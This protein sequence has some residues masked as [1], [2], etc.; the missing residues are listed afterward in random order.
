MA[1]Q[2]TASVVL[3]PGPTLTA[4]A[5][6]P[7]FALLLA[8]TGAAAFNAFGGARGS[9]PFW[10]FLGLGLGIWALDQGLWIYYQFW[11]H[12]CVPNE[13]IGDPALFLHTAPLMAAL[14][15]RPHLEPSSRRLHQTTFSFLLLVF[16]WV[17][18]YADY[19][20]PHQFLFPNPQMY[21]LRYNALYF[22]E[23]I[24][25]LIVAGTF[26]LCSD[27]PWKLL[28]AHLFGA[29]GLYTLTSEQVNAALNTGTS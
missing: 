21:A 18:L 13:S 15:T 7:Y 3:R 14:V 8:A 9:R 20:F 22:C 6:V 12:T 27:R 24:A 5:F 17:F 26:I 16:F 25:L 10:V 1:V 23:N 19:V 29:V 28:Y 11:L 4:C 2:A